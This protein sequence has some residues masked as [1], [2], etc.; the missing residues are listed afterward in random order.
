MNDYKSKGYIRKLSPAERSEWHKDA[1][2]LPHFIVINQNKNPPKPRLVF[3][4]AA[5]VK[6]VSFNSALLSGPDATTSSLGVTMRFREGRTA[7]AG[8]IKEMFS[9]IK[10]RPQ[11]QRKQCFLFRDCDQTRE[12]DV[13]VMQVMA[14]QGSVT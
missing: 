4:A 3:D 11:D 2:Y 12:P 8:D 5:K 13:Y 1:Y 14:I 7:I 10:I 9:Q 6:G